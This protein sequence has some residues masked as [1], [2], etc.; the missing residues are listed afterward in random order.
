MMAPAARRGSAS[1]I[2][3]G[4]NPCVVGLL[5]GVVTGRLDVVGTAGAQQYGIEAFGSVSWPATW[6][7][8]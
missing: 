1:T 8:R 4:R 6:R 5:P 2:P 3:T 7:C